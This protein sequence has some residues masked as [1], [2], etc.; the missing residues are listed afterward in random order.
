VIF[1]IGTMAE[2]EEYETKYDSID[3]DEVL[4]NYRLLTSYIKCLM[5]EGPCTPDGT[6]LKG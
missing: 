3:I 5:G 4:N 6:T 2:A 1:L